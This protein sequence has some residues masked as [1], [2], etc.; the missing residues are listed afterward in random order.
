MG[1]EP[2]PSQLRGVGSTTMLQPKKLNVD[3]HQDS[4]T[5]RKGEL[6]L[7]DVSELAHVGRA[8]V[9][10]NAALAHDLNIVELLTNVLRSWLSVRI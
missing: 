1:F 8:H 3:T 7:Q 4:A 5:L 2:T 6:D 9:P 10:A